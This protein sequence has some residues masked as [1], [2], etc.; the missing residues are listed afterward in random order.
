MC[1]QNK[2]ETQFTSNLHGCLSALGDALE[3]A[4]GALAPPLV[5]A[6]SAADLEEAVSISERLYRLGRQ[7]L[8]SLVQP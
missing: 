4:G 2:C 3:S 7:K 6:D 5:H 8:S 1:C